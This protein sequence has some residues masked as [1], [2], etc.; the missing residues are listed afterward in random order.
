MNP[1]LRALLA[2]LLLVVS[3]VA[4]PIDSDRER[5]LMPVRA[6]KPG[7]AIAFRA[8]SLADD[9]GRIAPE[10]L[11]RAKAH[12]AAMRAAR[13][14]RRRAVREPR[15]DDPA[16]GTAEAGTTAGSVD[17]QP[18]AAALAR[19]GWTALGPGNIGGRVRSVAIDPAAPDTMFAGSVGGGIWKTVDGGAAWEPVS[20]FMANLAV[21]SIVFHPGNRLVMYAGTGEGF[22]NIDAIRGAG[23]FKSTDGGASW[24]QLP[25]TA[26]ASF[27]HVLRLAM[28]PDGKVLLAG[29]TAGLFRSADGGATF[30]RIA[31]AP[32]AA[33]IDFHPTNALRAVAGDRAGQV[34]F[35]S[36]G[37]VTWA[38]ASLTLPAGAA[39]SLRAE[40][41]YA[42]G[43]PS[44]VYAVVDADGG[45]VYRSGDGGLSFVQT[46]ANG[47]VE[48]LENGQGWYDLALW[49]N[50]RDGND[51]LVGGVNLFRSRDGGHTFTPVSDPYGLHVDQHVIVEHP[52]FDDTSNRV[53]YIG[54]DGGVYRVPDLARLTSTTNA[55]YDELNNRLA[56]T[57]FYGAAGNPATG[58]IVGGTQDNG[59]LVYNPSAGTEGWSAM[60]GG[61]GGF[62]ASDPTDPNYFYG[63]YVYL[64][65]HRSTNGGLTSKFIYAGLSDAGRDANFI[66]PFVLD[67]N[68]PRRLLAGGR[69]LW[70]SD[71]IRAAAPAW[72]AI[73]TAAASNISAIA[74]A[75]GNSD[76]VWVGH[77][78]GD[79]YRTTNGRAASP[80]W[81]KV[82][83]LTFPNRF[84]T[85]I[86]I[87]PFD[88]GVA[89]VAFGGFVDGNIQRTLN[90]GATWEDATGTGTT[91]LPFA[92]V[93]DVEV[94]PSDPSVLWAAT[95]VGIFSSSDRGATWDPTQDGPANVSVEELFVLGDYL[96]A[97]THG[98]G[99]FR[100]ALSTAASAPAVSFS[101]ASRAYPSAYVGTSTASSPMTVVSSG[102]AP[103][104]IAAVSIAGTHG[105]DFIVT[106]NGCA[107]AVL[108]PGST[109]TIQVAFRPTAAGRRSARLS[110]S[111]NAAGSPHTAA[112]TGDGLAPTSPGGTLP[113]PWASRDIGAVGVAGSAAYSSG[114][115]T[116]A[117][118]G[119]DIWGTADAF[120]FV[121]QPL[122]G[123]G[124]IVARVGSVE[125]SAAW[126][127]A[128]VMVRQSLTAGSAH[129]FML[130][131]AAK[132]LAFQRRTAAGGLST[133]TSAGAGAAPRWVRLQRRGQVVTAF[134][135][136]DGIS[137]TPAGQ[138][139]I[140]LSGTV[141]VGLAVSS[142]DR[143]RTATATFNSVAVT[144]GLLPAGWQSRDIGSVG[145]AGSARE[146]GGTY[147]IRG[148][149]A[150]VWGT[151][152]A[153][154]FAYTPLSGDGTI[155]ARVATVQGTRAWTKIGVMMRG[156]TAANAAHAFML[157]SLGKGLAFQ[158]RTAAGALS[159]HT[160]GGSGTAPRWVR[161]ARAGNVITASA[162]VDG[163]I[164]T[165]VG[166]DTFSLPSS[167]LVGLAAHSHD[168][169]TLATGTF[170]NVR[171][172]RP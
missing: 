102:T 4:A 21:T 118:A 2:A 59:T 103:L 73:K 47:P 136:T 88:A 169:T 159:V 37:G 117:G 85:R 140:A 17:S 115:Y 50:P 109:C 55:W 86:T 125:S 132:G 93:R 29:T 15:T 40:V 32:A 82:D 158:R 148:A 71:D 64:Q 166:R 144:S 58:V 130:V 60:F 48:L 63:E 92:P 5:P 133:H 80:T 35:T 24:A 77:N 13:A 104:A 68:E 113:A 111:S 108:P 94:D 10:G 101:P 89:Y 76:I 87:D 164:W 28:S 65:I 42:R 120:R 96:Y 97:V 142:H 27:H 147:T 16:G 157:V 143:S 91:G 1:H 46:Y 44:V 100:H 146:S 165:T 39:G 61:D 90:G 155:V 62:A 171:L 160:S 79:V 45:A 168:V 12:V 131:S 67:P 128:G 127:K 14:Q 81:T 119:A 98:R 74:V 41:A 105:A 83:P 3:P 152:D 123:D 112:L 95:E 154:H 162:S 114:T 116:V 22:D 20:D 84:I 78:N 31:G 139:T 66:A 11:M 122:S 170:T 151:A 75:P 99:L 135:S 163:T 54:N 153:F 53:L 161:L 9:R 26:T 18:V 156:S 138:D 126:V 121:Y 43:T 52:R 129:A 69:S 167:I 145:A 19:D 25:S 134:H 57:Q 150:D 8:L 110:V 141:Y 6:D 106:T 36:D 7:E 107:N 34:W 172:F 23:V 38:K 137:W 70:R 124:S 56:I 49:V 30:A 51:L 33:D 72:R 149:G